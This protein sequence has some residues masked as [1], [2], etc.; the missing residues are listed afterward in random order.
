MPPPRRAAPSSGPSGFKPKQPLV[1][2]ERRRML[3]A[4]AWR[5]AR[6]IHSAPAALLTMNLPAMKDM[7]QQKCPPK[8]TTGSQ[9]GDAMRL[10]AKLERLRIRPQP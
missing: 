7:I 10:A 4:T 6:I 1:G 2:K 3:K 5:L 9:R 8:K